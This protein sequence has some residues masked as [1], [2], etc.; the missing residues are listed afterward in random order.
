[1]AH[2][3]NLKVCMEGIEVAEDIDKLKVYDPDKFQGFYFGRPCTADQF[4]EKYIRSDV[5][6]DR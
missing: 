1:M 5:R 2:E 3:L 6:F 4:R